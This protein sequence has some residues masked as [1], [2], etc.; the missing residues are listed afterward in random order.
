MSTARVLYIWVLLAGPTFTLRAGSALPPPAPA[1]NMHLAASVHRDRGRVEALRSHRGRCVAGRSPTREVG[2]EATLRRRSTRPKPPRPSAHERVVS[3][4][5]LECDRLPPPISLQPLRD[6]PVGPGRSRL[7]VA[8]RRRHCVPRQ[9]A[10]DHQIRLHQLLSLPHCL[11]IPPSFSVGPSHVS[12]HDM[13]RMGEPV[14]VKPAHRAPPSADVP[15]PRP[16]LVFE[17]ISDNDATSAR[18]IEG[19]GYTRSGACMR[20]CEQARS[21]H[22]RGARA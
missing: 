22:L 14:R 1:P 2:S 7:S 15:A 13:P 4:C 6:A 21:L 9:K 18:V 3:W 8:H 16:A 17:C 11:R 19:F 5:G 20:A 10:P 12:K